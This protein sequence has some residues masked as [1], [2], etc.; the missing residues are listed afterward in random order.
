MRTHCETVVGQM[1]EELVKYAESANNQAM[2][3]VERAVSQC[4]DTTA[5]KYKK[6]YQRLFSMSIS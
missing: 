2:E 6:Y 4:K 3:Y 5:S 1:K